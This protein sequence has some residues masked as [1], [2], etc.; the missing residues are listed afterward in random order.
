[1]YAYERK[2]KQNILIGIGFGTI[3]AVVCFLIFGRGYIAS[4]DPES[5]APEISLV[6][7]AWMDEGGGICYYG[8]NGEYAQYIPPIPDIGFEGRTVTGTW[9][10]DGNILTK[11]D[12][13]EEY[14]I[15]GNA[16]YWGN[17]VSYRVE[18]D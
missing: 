6:G 12:M 3:I 17:G 2:V 1:M 16:L 13:S 7:T 4:T 9:S 8:E 14:R 11:D 5:T 15:E 18:D 10:I